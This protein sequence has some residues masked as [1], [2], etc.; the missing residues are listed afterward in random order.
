[1]PPL[2]F[3]FRPGNCYVKGVAATASPRRY[4]TKRDPTLTGVGEAPPWN[5]EAVPGVEYHGLQDRRMGVLPVSGRRMR[6][7]LAMA[8][9]RHLDRAPITEALVDLRV[10]APAEFDPARF[11]DLAES[12]KQ[13]LPIREELRIIE[14]GTRIAGKQISQTIQ[15]RGLHGYALRTE[16]P[17]R[18]A[19]FRRDGFTFNKLRPYTSWQEVFSQ[20]WDLWQLYVEKARP[21]IVSRVAVRYINHLRIP[22]PYS[23]DEYL[24]DPPTLSDGAPTQLT[25]YFKRIAVSD[26]SSNVSANV[27]QALEQ[28]PEI[29]T[30]AF[31][32]DIDVYRMLEMDPRDSALRDIFAQLQETK[33][34]IFF[35]AITDQ[36]AEMYE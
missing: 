4:Q 19:Q 5:L 20:A 2:G 14:S 10:Q 21:L 16:G 11:A 18:I 13:D 17:D 1:M 3:A 29:N 26:P 7:K 35:G 30:V 22:Y 15:D 9:P 28:G 33:N 23:F 34:S 27:I 8:R 6:W 32:L 25:D 12:L 31:L 24:S 36:A